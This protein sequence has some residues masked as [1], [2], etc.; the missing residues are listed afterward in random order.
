MIM[1]GIL[2]V[3][4]IVSELVRVDVPT[5]NDCMESSYVTG[6]KIKAGLFMS[7]VARKPETYEGEWL[8]QDNPYRH[9]TFYAKRAKKPKVTTGT[10]KNSSTCSQRR[11]CTVRKT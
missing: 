1:F 11:R 3:L 2:I 6:D 10:L 9:P 8:D 7:A 4:I 5:I